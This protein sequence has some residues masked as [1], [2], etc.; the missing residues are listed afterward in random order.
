MSELVHSFSDILEEVSEA[1]CS[2]NIDATA[3]INKI[4]P[5]VF[6]R[7][8]KTKDIAF[9]LYKICLGNMLLRIYYIFTCIISR[10][11]QLS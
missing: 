8:H 1:V 4:S 11:N 2:L 6:S 5:A 7:T 10:L 9:A 3:N